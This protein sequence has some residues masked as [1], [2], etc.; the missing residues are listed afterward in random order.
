MATEE[1]GE[2]D[3]DSTGITPVAEKP[4]PRKI[5]RVLPVLPVR[6]QVYFPRMLFPLF[7][8][9]EKSIRALETAIARNRYIILVAQK[10]ITTED[11]EP[12]DIYDVGL[13]TEV[14]QILRV[15]DGTMRVMLEGVERVRML[16]YVQTEPYLR[17]RIKVLPTIEEKTLEIEAL[18]RSITTQ[19]EQIVQ[20]ARTI[21]PEALLNVVNIDE[22]GRLADTITPYLPLKVD[23]KQEIL[24]SLPVR[25]R[26]EKLN[27]LLE[28]EVQ[29]QEITR[30]IRTRV[31]KEMGDTQREFILREQT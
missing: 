18:M 12:E 19:F 6:D 4:V 2:F 28:R 30:D 3:E 29:V 5:P 10:E 15:P 22:P 20:N 26:L 21:P 17:A 13:L 8:G 25:R 16:S 1:I 24:E 27:L 31:E 14:M 9:R 11:P 7:V 23:A